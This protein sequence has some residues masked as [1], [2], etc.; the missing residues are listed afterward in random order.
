MQSAPSV[1]S[2]DNRLLAMCHA[3]SPQT[4]V[5][6][7]RRRELLTTMT[8]FHLDCQTGIIGFRLSKKD[9][10]Y[11][12]LTPEMKSALLSYRERQE[13]IPDEFVTR[14]VTYLAQYPSHDQA[15][16]EFGSEL[17]L[18][19]LKRDY[20]FIKEL[21]EKNNI[22]DVMSQSPNGKPSTQ[23]LH[24]NVK[25]SSPDEQTQNIEAFLRD[26]DNKMEQYVKRLQ[27]FE[28]AVPV[29]IPADTSG[30]EGPSAFNAISEAPSEART[31]D[32]HEA[33]KKLD[34]ESANVV[35]ECCASAESPAVPASKG[36]TFWI[37]EEKVITSILDEKEDMLNLVEDLAGTESRNSFEK[38]LN[39]IRE[40]AI[41]LPVLDRSKSEAIPQ[42]L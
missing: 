6:S 23:Y 28:D 8:S 27:Q 17:L 26:F 5:V 42:D 2:L 40:S 20:R 24:F 11:Y 10:Y 4:P 32:S 36:K 15:D 37:I 7:E 29:V 31:A 1:P 9:A 13:V 35:S 3:L 18:K 21:K 16:I 30:A 41:E 39:L 25:T 14:I 34:K 22:L 33:N 12:R 19:V 38:R